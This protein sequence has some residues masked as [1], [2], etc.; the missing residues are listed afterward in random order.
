MRIF[1]M[2][3][4]NL[5]SIPI[6]IFGFWMYTS[7]M[8]QSFPTL[9]GKRIVLLI[10]HPD[11][12]AMFFAPALLS[13]SRP[14]LGNH[15]KILCLSTGDSEGIGEIRR[16]ELM[17]SGLSLG[18]RSSEDIL[19][20][21]DK[22]FPD[23]PEEWDAR[24]ISNLLTQNFSPKMPTL[25][26]NSRPEAGIDV[27]LTF[28]SHGV[29]SHPNHK[30]LYHGAHLYLKTL[31]SRHSGWECPI[32]LYVL[33][34][35][36]ILRKYLG[37]FDIPFTISQAIFHKKKTGF[38][39]TPLVM[40]SGVADFRKAQW[41]MYGAHKSQMLWFRWGWIWGSRY[42]VVNDLRKE[43]PATRMT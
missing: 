24:Q 22:N 40:V 4:Y 15:I 16:K 9:T 5:A 27:L 36:S 13:L 34:T 25:S 19:V 32:A 20:L 11:D 39:P 28:D 38:F 26:P 14:E 30:S 29:S 41:A 37:I 33:T 21:D 43:G 42:M 1:K 17:M 10:A 8:T 35:T 31:M 3:W 23:G 12:E 18:L 6:I 7:Q 2:E